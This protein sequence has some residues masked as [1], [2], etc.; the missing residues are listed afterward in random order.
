MIHKPHK[1]SYDI[2]MSKD[3]S[4]PLIMPNKKAILSKFQ[5]EIE[6]KG[7]LLDRTDIF[8]Y[9]HMDTDYKVYVSSNMQNSFLVNISSIKGRMLHCEL[10]DIKGTSKTAA[11][12]VFYSIYNNSRARAYSTAPK[13]VYSQASTTEPAF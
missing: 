6:N 11:D 4:R 13:A 1:S 9:S 7:I 12:Q 3:I 10:I 5:Q 2:G 8:N